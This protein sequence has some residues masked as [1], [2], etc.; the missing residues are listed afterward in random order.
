MSEKSLKNA[1]QLQRN[2][3][4][5]CTSEDMPFAFSGV[6]IKL[7]FFTESYPNIKKAQ[8]DVRK[9]IAI[10]NNGVFPIKET[11][12]FLRQGNI[13]TLGM[14]LFRTDA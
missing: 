4:A 9:I 6:C 1:G 10:T 12:F 2:Q 13:F 8:V 7:H 11:V 5:M 14:R 3:G